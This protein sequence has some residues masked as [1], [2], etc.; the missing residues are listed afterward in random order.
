[1]R[2]VDIDLLLNEMN[3]DKTKYT[4]QID[5]NQRASK[6]DVIDITLKNYRGLIFDII[7]DLPTIEVPQWIPVEEILPENDNDILIFYKDDIHLGWYDNG[8]SSY[9]EWEDTNVNN[10]VLF[11]MKLPDKPYQKGTR[12]ENSGNDSKIG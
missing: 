6:K 8:F 2:I 1:M 7:K 11:W 5:I 10:D 3:N 4:C 9:S 12:W